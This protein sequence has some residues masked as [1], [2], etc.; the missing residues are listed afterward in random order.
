[1]II[2]EFKSS[3]DLSDLRRKYGGPAN[4]Y[5]HIFEQLKNKLEKQM[6]NESVE[7]RVNLE[8]AKTKKVILKPI[9]IKDPRVYMPSTTN[10]RFDINRNEEK[11]NNI[12]Q[13]EEKKIIK[14]KLHLEEIKEN[15]LSPVYGKN[16]NRYSNFAKTTYVDYQKDYQMDPEKELKLVKDNSGM[17]AHPVMN[18]TLV[19]LSKPPYQIKLEEMITLRV[20]KRSKN[21]GVVKKMLHAPS[22]KVYAIKVKI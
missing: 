9:E 20:I 19:T 14:N 17:I 21:L 3:T 11:S 4:F 12:Y 2:K 22:L 18:S 15:Q 6:A 5:N 1:M 10:I 8:K 7:K 16:G 13:F